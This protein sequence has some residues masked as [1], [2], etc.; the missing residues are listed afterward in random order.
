KSDSVT[1]PSAMFGPQSATRRAD[2]DQIAQAIKEAYE[3]AMLHAPTAIDTSTLDVPRLKSSPKR[4]WSRLLTACG[5]ITSGTTKRELVLVLR[6]C[7]YNF[8][9]DTI[10]W[11]AIAATVYLT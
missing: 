11:T 4:H 6:D 7:W 2:M 5:H 3:A 8:A 9:Y 1:W 10:K